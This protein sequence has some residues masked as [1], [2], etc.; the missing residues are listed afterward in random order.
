MSRPR[1]LIAEPL[2]EDWQRWLAE[3]CDIT[4][5]SS[6]NGRAF[7]DAL[8][9]ADALVVR[10]YTTVDEGLLREAPAL[11]VVGRA[12]VG[13]DNIDVPAC[14]ARGVEVVH[15]PEANAEAVAELTLAFVFDAIRPRTYLEASLAQAAW[16]DLRSSLV[17]RG[18]I[19]GSTYGVLGLGRIGQR[20]AR[21]AGAMR[22]RVVYHDVLDIPRA[23]RA[24]ADPVEFDALLRESDILSIHV[25]GS[26]SNRALLDERA[27]RSLRPDVI[28]VNTSR[29]FVIDNA[30]LARFLRE[31]PDA[32]AMLDV[33]EPEPIPA[34]HPLLDLPNA[35]LA[36]HIGA[37][38]APAKRAMSGV[39]Q[40]VWRVLCREEPRHPAPP[41]H[42]D[43]PTSRFD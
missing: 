18:Q 25:G 39:V 32:R 7:R 41:E 9:Q 12:G 19:A 21:A 29:G 31:H 14:R 43:E 27:I 33:H 11:R 6:D 38:T 5:R 17:A 36:P 13:L 28:L 35:R 34:D 22:A 3:R 16:D 37:A 8:A 20:V 23:E 10:T 2:H 1:A 40:D 42:A 30:A 15:T 4:R 26:E 24:G